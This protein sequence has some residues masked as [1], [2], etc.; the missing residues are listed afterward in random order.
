MIFRLRYSQGQYKIAHYVFREV[1][2]FIVEEKLLSRGIEYIEVN[3]SVV[4]CMR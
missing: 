4:Q 1:C 3:L 2:R